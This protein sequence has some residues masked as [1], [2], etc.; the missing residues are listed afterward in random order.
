MTSFKPAVAL[1]LSLL[2]AAPAFAQIEIRLFPPA[3]FRAT[4]RPE[5]YEGRPTY[6]YRGQ[7]YYREHGNWQYYREEPRELRERHNGN[8]QHYEHGHR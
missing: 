6:F 7:W 3:A 2:V 4:A 5:Y 1:T 8:R